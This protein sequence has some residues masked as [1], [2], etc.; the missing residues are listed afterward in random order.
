MITCPACGR[1]QTTDDVDRL[2]PGGRA[3]RVCAQRPAR[4]ILLAWLVS[5]LILWGLYRLA[6]VLML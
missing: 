1:D 6:R 5:S 3:C 4:G 2:L